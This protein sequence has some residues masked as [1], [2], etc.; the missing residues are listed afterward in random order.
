MRC[1]NGNYTYFKKFFFKLGQTGHIGSGK[2][3]NLMWLL[4]YRKIPKEDQHEKSPP[5]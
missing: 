5:L 4:F 3:N 1:L 2:N